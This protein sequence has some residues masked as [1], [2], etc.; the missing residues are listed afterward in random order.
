MAETIS[1]CRRFTAMKLDRLLNARSLAVMQEERREPQSCEWLGAELGWLSEPEADVGP[2]GAHVMEEQVGVGLHPFEAQSRDGARS[3]GQAGSMTAP[4]A[5]RSEDQ[6]A[7]LS[8]GVERLVSGQRQEAYERVGVIRLLFGDLRLVHGIHAWRD[9]LA[10]D[11]FLGGHLGSR[12]SH[13]GREGTEIELA[14]SRH[15]R[16]APESPHAP[17]QKTIRASR[18]SIVV[19]ILRVGTS[20][21]LAVGDGIEQSEAENGRSTARRVPGGF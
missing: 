21:D 6:A 16:L 3:R 10:P 17:V 2:L 8:F 7:P 20:E 1:R 4:T 18:D 14:E 19:A 13:L 15:E 11:G 5:D 12:D 9:R